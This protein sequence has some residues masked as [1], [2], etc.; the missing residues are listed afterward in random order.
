MAPRPLKWRSKPLRGRTSRQR[1]EDQE[2]NTPC[3]RRLSLIGFVI[4]T[5]PSISEANTLW[6]E[7]HLLA[8]LKFVFILSVFS[9]F[10]SC[11][12]TFK[13]ICESQS[14]Q[15]LLGAA[16]T[17]ILSGV[18]TVDT[19]RH[20][21]GSFYWICLSVVTEGNYFNKKQTK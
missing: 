5:I 21:Q 1:L 15:Q 8:K 13:I 18:G 14:A 19:K 17:L 12:D 3:F 9:G 4:Q 20:R 10:L 2:S 6:M 16:K 11:E 7:M